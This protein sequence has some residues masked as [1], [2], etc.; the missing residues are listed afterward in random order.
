MTS[1]LEE[2]A[3]YNKAG[4]SAS[5]SFLPVVKSARFLINRE[6]DEYGRIL[7][8]IARQ[9][10][11][12]DITVKL[13]Q[14][15]V[16]R[17]DSV[18][19]ES[20]RKITEQ[21]FAFKIFVWIDME[22]RETVDP[23]IEIFRTVSKDFDNVGICLQAYLSRTGRD[24]KLLLA[25]GAPIRLVKGFY[26]EHDF[27]SWQEVSE[28]YLK[29][30]PTLL[31]ESSFPAIATHDEKIINEAKKVIREK[32]IRNAEFQ[33]FKGVRDDLASEL[34]KQGFKVRVYI[35]YGNFW[36]FLL[37]GMRTFDLLHN[38]ERML[39]LRPRG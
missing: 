32:N 15:G 25:Q 36:R 16:Y 8:S 33:F 22:T 38:L 17:D 1:A 30:L 11:D 27:K 18:T 9:K 13:H 14:L 31:T 35:P 39:N 23:T 10:L 12:C 24:M 6:I 5:L 19:E 34:V 7:I 26:Q 37:K 4:I 28:N 2:V 20:V 3:E 21:A 29:L